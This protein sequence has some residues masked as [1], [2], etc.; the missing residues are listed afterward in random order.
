MVTTSKKQLKY[1]R[2]AKQAGMTLIELTVVLLVLVGLAGLMV[3]YVGSFVEKTNDSTGSSNLAQLNNAMGRFVTERNRLPH[4]LESLINN[5]AATAA[6]SGACVGAT[7]G[8][9]F[10]GLAN[11]AAFEPVT[12][13]GGT[14]AGTLDAIAL[15]SLKDAN[16]YMWI[17]NNQDAAN[18]TF[19]SGTAMKYL[20]GEGG[21]L[22]TA[23]V[24]FARLPAGAT[25]T[26]PTTNGMTDTANH[27]TRQLLSKVLGGAGMDYYPECYDYI[28]MGVG[29]SAELI[30]KTINSSPVNFPKD[31]EKG[32]VQNYNHYIAIFQVDRANA[33]GA[34]LMGSK[35]ECS[36][37]TEA[38]K[39]LG[40][41]LNT[42]DTAN[43]GLIGVKNALET[44]YN[45]KVGE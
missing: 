13:T 2:I 15:E 9:V 41:V 44:T 43:N 40:T 5:G 34:T 27:G 22:A 32:P 17:N 16:M 4:H 10:C 39:F 19:S 28:A 20:P 8:T 25:N 14:A 26:D 21:T 3:P 31:A 37:H 38:T 33:G 42:A 30:G 12:Y 23:A 6:A 45:N 1:N 18:K 7:A 36:T 24:T 35:Y 29:D 11:T